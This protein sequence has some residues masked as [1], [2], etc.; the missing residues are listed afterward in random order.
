MGITRQSSGSLSPSTFNTLTFSPVP[1]VQVVAAGRVTEFISLDGI[2]L[3]VLSWAFLRVLYLN[4]GV[5]LM[6]H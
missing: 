2:E 5:S 4:F 3:S 6:T 1:L